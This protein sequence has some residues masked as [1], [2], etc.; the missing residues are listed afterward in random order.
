MDAEIQKVC[1]GYEPFVSAGLVSTTEGSLG[2]VPVRVLRDTGASQ[3][4]LRA[5]VLP[6]SEETSCG[7][8]ALVQGIEMATV[9][10][11]L[12][13]VHLSTDL[14][15]GCFKMAVSEALPVP[16]IDVLLGNDIAGGRVYPTL[17]VTNQPEVDLDP[18]NS[19]VYPACV[20]T[21]SQARKW[22]DFV[23]LEDSFLAKPLTTDT[24]ELPKEEKSLFEQLPNIRLPITRERLI[25]MQKQDVT[26]K[27]C[28]ASA[29]TPEIAASKTV[30]YY[31]EN[32]LLMRKWSSSAMAGLDWGEV[33][34]VVIPTPFRRQVLTLAH[35][36]PWAGH[37]GV[38]KT[39]QRLLRHFFWPKMKSYVVQHCRTC[40]T[41]QLAGKPNPTSSGT[42]YRGA[43]QPCHNGLC[44]APA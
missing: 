9:K 39:Y 15:S 20:L 4:F 36:N 23:G 22:G 40:P 2:Q 29:V 8:D 1:S 5:G 28:L 42:S 25:E 10:A 6:L 35:E 32:G 38:N 43:L 19:H 26:L 16:N 44:W 11:P 37:L 34:Q 24:A 3:S 21:R 12:H 27:D 7:T 41:C 14:A 18:I 30:V 31:V 33:N 17:E 13:M